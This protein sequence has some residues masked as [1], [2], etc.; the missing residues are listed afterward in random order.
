VATVKKA[1]MVGIVGCA[2]AASAACGG[3]GAK[4]GAAG[5][6]HSDAY[7]AGY[8]AGDNFT[9]LQL[10][11]ATWACAMAY[12]NAKGGINEDEYFQGCYDG[13]VKHGGVFE[14]PDETDGS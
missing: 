1:L 10:Q 12:G 5:N 11:T 13:A 8:K 9:N 7:N 2:I 3:G 14:N 4:S 6:G